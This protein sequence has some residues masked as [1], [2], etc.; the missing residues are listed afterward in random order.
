[1]D[2][3]SVTRLVGY[4]KR[5]VI[6]DFRADPYLWYVFVVAV[7]MLGFWFW[8]QV[9]SFATHDEHTRL[10]D[11]MPA[12]GVLTTGPG[13]EAFQNGV[14]QGRMYGATFYLN[15]I[16]LLPAVVFAIITDQLAVF[17][18]F[19]RPNATA[20]I[21]TVDTDVWLLW[22]STPRWV[23]TSSL[24]I[25]R[26]FSVVFA[27]GCVYLVYR[28]TSQL[29][30]RTAGRLAALVLSF[31]FGFV[32]MA[33]ESGEDVPSAFL[34]LLVIY[35]AL[36]Y[37]ETGDERYFYGGCGV[38]GF[39]MAFKLTA[40]VSVILLATAQFLRARKADSEWLRALIR[41]RLLVVGALVGISAMIVGYPSVLLSGP[42]VLLARIT[43]GT[44]HKATISGGRNAS[45]GWW[46]LRSYLNGFGVVLFLA[47]IGSV[48]AILPQLRTHS[49]KTDGLV[50]L[51]VAIASC[52]GLLSWWQYI[53]MH[54]LLL[55]IPPLVILVSVAL[56]Q[57]H[58]RTETVARVVVTVVL[59]SSALYTGYGTLGYADQPR[60]AATDWL[61]TNA[62]EDATVELY[63]IH[64]QAAAIPH[65]MNTSHY[66]HRADGELTRPETTYGEWM[67]NMP[68]RC[69]EYIELT[70]EDL[71]RLAPPD[72]NG[73]ANFYADHHREIEYIRS[74]MTDP[75]DS[76][77]VA[78]EFG[79]R[80][81]FLDRK[82]SQSPLPELLRV[83]IVPRTVQYG[84]EQDLGPE[85]YTLILK[86]TGPCR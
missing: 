54:H 68:D 2:V 52:L 27:L 11:V 32:V 67:Q 74:L 69:P 19:Y 39:A 75:N 56:W 81:R 7:V 17:T 30:D 53:R 61:A 77:E 49:E 31:T 29:R 59:V 50:L 28:I 4:A 82:R 47:V 46:M 76:Y 38:G 41:P 66:T 79:Q 3:R 73:R 33:H 44:T 18:P 10:L 51:V 8:H 84:D 1:M 14:T 13:F 65:G 9:P 63:Q 23:W 71:L 24:L 34:L 15:A 85:Q 36:R 25:V 26:L 40:G 5:R 43:R 55:T 20:H 35:L 70:R 37:V 60:A 83:G 86:R 6:Q 80:P 58:E 78:A 48:A 22:H 57:L 12:I 72:L 45:S 42:E 21:W 16:A 64:P 62:P